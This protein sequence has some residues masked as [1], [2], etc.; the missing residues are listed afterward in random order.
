MFV[1]FSE[2]SKVEELAKKANLDISKF[3][4]KELVRGIAVE[5]EHDGKQ[6]KDVD[7]V[8]SETDLLKIALAHLREDPKY[9]T[10][11]KKVEGD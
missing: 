2:W 8:G 6:G 10:K 9:Y 5:R 11:L 4:R 1:K 7:V 3:D